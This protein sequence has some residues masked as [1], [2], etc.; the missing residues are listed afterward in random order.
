[1]FAMMSDLGMTFEMSK[2]KFLLVVNHI[3]EL[4][5]KDTGDG[6]YKQL[7]AERGRRLLR[8]AREDVR[9]TAIFDMDLA[10]KISKLP[11]VPVQVPVSV[12]PGGHVHYEPSVSSFSEVAAKSCGPLVFTVMPLLDEDIAPPQIY[13]SS[14]GILTGPALEV[15]LKHLRMITSTEVLDRW[16]HPNITPKKTFGAIFQYLHDH[17]R[18]LSPNVKAALR[19]SPLVPVGHYLVTPNRLFF[20]LA[21]DLSPFMHEVP[22]YYGANEQFLK[23]VGVKESP[24]P[25]DYAHFLKDLAR[26]CAESPLNPNELRAV[27]AIVQSLSG[28]D[29]GLES[30]EKALHLPDEDSI[31]QPVSVCLINDDSWL[32]GRAGSGVARAGYFFVHPLVGTSVSAALHVPA[33]SEV[34][35]EHLHGEVEV[36]EEVPEAAAAKVRLQNALQNKEFAQSV[37]ALLVDSS[38]RAASDLLSG[39]DCGVEAVV[40]KLSILE[41]KFVHELPTFLSLEDR[42]AHNAAPIMLSLDDGHASK[43]LSFI[44]EKQ[45][46][47]GKFSLYINYGAIAPPITVEIAVAMGLCRYVGLSPSLAATLGY[48]LEASHCGDSRDLLFNLRVGSDTVTLRERQR[49]MPGEKVA[50]SDIPLLELKPFRMFRVGETVVFKG[51][52]PA[53]SPTKKPLERAVMKA[54]DEVEASTAGRDSP[55]IDPTSDLRYGR[56]TAIGDAEEAGMRRITVKTGSDGTNATLLS[57]EVFSFMS[58]RE[59]RAQ[60]TSQHS[61]GKSVARF[62]GAS[63]G[64]GAGGGLAELARNAAGGNSGKPLELAEAGGGGANGPPTAETSE[65]ISKEEILRAISGLLA[66]AG[67]PAHLDTQEM[68]TRIMDLN[69]N[70]KRLENELQQERFEGNK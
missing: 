54:V 64:G 9:S 1:M 45:S 2:E 61:I 37:A 16:N 65:P 26:E 34:I 66:R 25:I 60:R 48:L 43:T 33:V 41:L 17:W 8:Y 32:R 49:G 4:V 13:F 28:Q 42:R 5:R 19:T 21:E 55:S 14:L 30:F 58:A 44:S 35:R 23:N 11:F 18:A 38:S 10:R 20:R 29:V 52:K 6:A 56:V 50:A 3:V 39:M 36:A 62:L 15:V 68:L 70:V 59:A 27:I 53:T 57:T 69:G 46:A 67:V 7:A 12:E 22:R 47:G 31:L 63:A 24:T 51:S 40:V